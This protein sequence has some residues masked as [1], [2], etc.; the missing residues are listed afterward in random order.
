MDSR[1]SQKGNRNDKMG[2][3]SGVDMNSG[4]S[5]MNHYGRNDRLS[6]QDDFLESEEYDSV[7]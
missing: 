1:Q 2:S 7:C 3:M 5:D 4:R 6:G